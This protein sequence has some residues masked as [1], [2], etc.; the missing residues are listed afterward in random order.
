M[1]TQQHIRQSRITDSHLTLH[2]LALK[3]HASA[4]AVAE[5]AGLPVDRAKSLLDQAAA[6]G[7]VAEVKGRYMLTPLA[8][9]ALQAEYARYYADIR[10]NGAFLTSHDAF[11]KINADLKALI[12]DWQTVEIGGERIANDH[13]DQSYDEKIID[14]L[15]EIHDRVEPVLNSL[16]VQVPRLTL[17]RDRLESALDRA[18]A[19]DIEWVSSVHIDSY[20]TVWFELHEDLLRMIGRARSE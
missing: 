2:A 14:R 3:K 18:E 12:T 4:E 8:Q 20:H 6:Q 15:A 13:A 9:I 10:V 17:W 1:G 11:E 5:I 16:A 19:G 7:Q